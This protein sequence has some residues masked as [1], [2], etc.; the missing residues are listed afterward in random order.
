M[1][2]TAASHQG[3]IKTFWASLLEAVKSSI[4]IYRLLY[5]IIYFTY[6][7]LSLPFSM[8]VVLFHY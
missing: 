8:L 5:I 4:F 1:T 2:Y 7:I 6:F 3:A